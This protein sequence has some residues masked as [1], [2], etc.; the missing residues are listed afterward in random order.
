[1]AS[2]SSPDEIKNE[3]KLN[4]TCFWTL[5]VKNMQRK[6][7]SIIVIVFDYGWASLSLGPMLI[8]AQNQVVKTVSMDAALVI[9]TYSKILHVATLASM[10]GFF[11]STK[12]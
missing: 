10:L 3:K 5:L 4:F 12:R 6:N 9:I 11:Y 2:V 1:M 7:E 8:N